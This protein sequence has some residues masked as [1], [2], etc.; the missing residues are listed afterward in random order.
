MRH[1]PQVCGRKRLLWRLGGL[2]YLNFPPSTQ[3]CEYAT[4]VAKTLD[5]G[6]AVPALCMSPQELGSGGLLTPR[7]WL[8]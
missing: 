6:R 4:G 7:F 2:F 1:E 8:R 3:S 5:G